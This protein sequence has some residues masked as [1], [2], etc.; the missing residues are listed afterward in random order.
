VSWIEET[1]GEPSTV[2]TASGGR[3][4]PMLVL[5]PAPSAQPGPGPARATE[6]VTP[7]EQVFESVLI[8]LDRPLE[9]DR[10]GAALDRWPAGVVRVKGIV[11][12]AEGTTPHVVQR[13]GRRWSIEPLDPTPDHPGPGRLLVI[14]IRATVDLAGLT[15]ELL[16]PPLP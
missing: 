6:P 4:D 12:L 11:T 1:V 7:A 13:V 9:R 3:V 16:E 10:L 2:L 14:G 15:A 8:E 5:D